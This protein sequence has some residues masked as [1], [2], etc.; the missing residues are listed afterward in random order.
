MQYPNQPYDTSQCCK[1]SCNDK[2]RLLNKPVKGMIEYIQQVCICP[3]K[4][5]RV[6][7]NINKI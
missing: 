7:K 1:K 2:N 3:L 4:M 6:I 5:K